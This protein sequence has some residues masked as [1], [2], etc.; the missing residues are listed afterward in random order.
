MI[1]HGL[2]GVSWNPPASI[3]N[4]AHAIQPLTAVL[5]NAWNSAAALLP[6]Q[7][8]LPRADNKVSMVVDM[9][10]IRYVRVDNHAPGEVITIGSDRWKVFPFYRKNVAVRDAGSS[11]D[12][13]GTFGFAVRYD[14]P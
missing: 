13:T 7:V 6:V 4:C 11:V 8:W 1:N 2:D 3:L 5:P 12:H 10:H 14:G 9:V